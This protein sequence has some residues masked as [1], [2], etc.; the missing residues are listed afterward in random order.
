[1]EGIPCQP[2]RAFKISEH[3]QFYRGRHVE[4]VLGRVVMFD[5]LLNNDIRPKGQYCVVQDVAEDSFYN[6]PSKHSSKEPGE[7]I[8]IKQD[9]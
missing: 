2:V 6:H 8:E 7:I 4:G 3:V 9:V 1:M 5:P